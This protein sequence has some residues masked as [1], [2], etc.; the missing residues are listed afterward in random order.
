VAKY[1]DRS[2]LKPLFPNGPGICSI[3]A[4]STSSEEQHGGSISSPTE[5]G[6]DGRVDQW[7]PKNP[8][9]G[10][11]RPTLM[12]PCPG[13]SRGGSERFWLREINAEDYGAHPADVI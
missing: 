3:A 13:F 2:V 9:S 1:H 8:L 10:V 7:V 4:S 12:R 5:T 6:R 11:Q